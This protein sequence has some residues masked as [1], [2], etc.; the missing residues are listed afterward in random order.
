MNLPDPGCESE[1]AHGPSKPRA[2]GDIEPGSRVAIGRLRLEVDVA[3]VQ[4]IEQYMAR[5]VGEDGCALVLAHNLHSAYLYQ[6]DDD[7]RSAY[8]RADLV[9][10]DGWPIL[11]TLNGQRR[12]TGSTRLGTEYRVGSTDWIPTVLNLDELERLCVLGA[13]PESNAAFLASIAVRLPALKVLGLP[14]YPW[15]ES[16]FALVEKEIA[17]FSPQL[18][19]I[20]M[21]MPLQEAVAIRLLDKRL[22]GVLATVGGAIDQMAGTQ[23]H[24]PRWTGKLR[25]EWLWRLCSDP[26]RLAFRY[27]LEPILLLRHL[28]RDGR[29]I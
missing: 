19:L 26:R 11:A 23:A 8:A 2:S 14:G 29:K 17:D 10:I 28:H 20:G 13:S 7:F 16:S 12:K 27:I 9:V 21:G 18:T 15:N 6:V 3:N 1:E 25:V 22:G 4:Q 5:V 24:A